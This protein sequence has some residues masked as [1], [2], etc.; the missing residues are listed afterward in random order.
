MRRPSKQEVL[1]GPG[2]S[3]TMNGTMAGDNP[4]TVPPS[5]QEAILVLHHTFFL[6]SKES[7]SIGL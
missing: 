4:R 2:T 6:L 7:R 5:S 3:C 1:L